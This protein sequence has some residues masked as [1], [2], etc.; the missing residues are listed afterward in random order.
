MNIYYESLLSVHNL[1]KA[2]R[3]HTIIQTMK[4]CAI[5]SLVGQPRASPPKNKIEKINSNSNE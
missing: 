4:V 5:H 2:A 1:A 3:E